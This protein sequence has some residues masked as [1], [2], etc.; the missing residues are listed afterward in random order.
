M[1]I[2]TLQTKTAAVRGILR[3]FA[4]AHE[5]GGTE[6]EARTLHEAAKV[7]RK[8]AV[9]A[10]KENLKMK[11]ARLSAEHRFILDCAGIMKERDTGGRAALEARYE[12][13][14]GY[15]E[16]LGRSLADFAAEYEGPDKIEEYVELFRVGFAP[17]SY[18][19]SPLEL[20]E[21]A[22]YECGETVQEMNEVIISDEPDMPETDDGRIME[23]FRA[24][25]EA[26]LTAGEG[27]KD[28]AKIKS[29]MTALKG[30]TED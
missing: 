6:A 9:F 28:K 24:G 11:S 10:G 26:G 19:S 21:N 14:Y 13:F 1:S 7:L 2:K 5:V 18:F 17:D 4:R 22:F 30:G 29:R 12:E 3:D 20:V 8:T 15:I 23:A 25:V 16:S 27:G